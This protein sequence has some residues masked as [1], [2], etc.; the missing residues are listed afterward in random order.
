[1]QEHSAA[2]NGARQLESA[3]ADS[4]PAPEGCF[5]KEKRPVEWNRRGARKRT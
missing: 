4:A 1:M 3:M 5:S 2:A